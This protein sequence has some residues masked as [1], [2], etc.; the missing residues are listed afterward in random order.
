MNNSPGQSEVFRQLTSDLEKLQAEIKHE[1][2]L[3]QE[4]EA[5]YALLKLHYEQAINYIKESLH[6]GSKN[7][8]SG[9]AFLIL[10]IFL[11]FMLLFYFISIDAPMPNN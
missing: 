7:Q 9:C 8:G 6:R 4:A 10:L 2:A 3:R 11:L 5:D 1:R